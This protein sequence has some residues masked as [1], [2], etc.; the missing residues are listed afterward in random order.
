[1]LSLCMCSHH[2]WLLFQG[3]DS[4]NAALPSES[5]QAL[6]NS[7]RQGCS[8]PAWAPVGPDQLSKA[9]YNHPAVGPDQLSAAADPH[10]AALRDAALSEQPRAPEE[11]VELP[12][13]AA[14]PKDDERG[15]T[16]EAATSAAPDHERVRQLVAQIRRLREKA[17]IPTLDWVS[18][19]PDVL[20]VWDGCVVYPACSCQCCSTGCWPGRPAYA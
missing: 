20:G 15:G 10:P 2:M 3:D 9:A 12:F 13:A 17:K 16:A 5:V 6:V 18:W 8:L 14:A 7:T 4:W 11:V 19:H 1:M